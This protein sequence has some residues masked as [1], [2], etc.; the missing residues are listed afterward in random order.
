MLTW[1]KNTMATMKVQKTGMAVQNLGN[2]SNSATS[3]P[4]TVVAKG[5]ARVAMVIESPNY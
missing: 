3:S 4:S 2:C 5:T 1:A